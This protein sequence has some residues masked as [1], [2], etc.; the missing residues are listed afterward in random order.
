VDIA[1][2]EPDVP[3]PLVAG[4]GAVVLAAAAALVVALVVD[5]TVTF[6]TV[7]PMSYSDAFTTIDDPA[8]ELV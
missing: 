6:D 4:V 8:P 1:P 5:P 2:P 7:A 3:P